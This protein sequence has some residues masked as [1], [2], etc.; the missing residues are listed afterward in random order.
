MEYH[1][2][3][4]EAIRR[5]IATSGL[6]SAA[7]RRLYEALRDH[8][9]TASGPNLGRRIVAPVPCV[10]FDLHIEDTDREQTHHV[11]FWVDDGQEPDTRVVIEVMLRA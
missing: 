11:Y 10:V 7:T 9:K 4:P 3:I 6:S 2:V 1:V 5:K 8:L